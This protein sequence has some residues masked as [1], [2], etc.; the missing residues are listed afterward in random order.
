MGI[1]K[2][3]V[4]LSIEN[5]PGLKNRSSEIIGNLYSIASNR[6]GLKQK[7]GYKTGKETVYDILEYPENS[8]QGAHY[9]HS[10]NWVIR[11]CN[12]CPARS[13]CD[14]NNI[15]HY[16]KDNIAKCVVMK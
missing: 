13:G 15:I 9:W 1:V 5:T 6:L 10:V 8:L 2:D 11:M 16:K 14:G 3:S 4:C 7:C 12:D